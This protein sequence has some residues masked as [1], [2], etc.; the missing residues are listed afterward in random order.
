VEDVLGLILGGGRGERLYPLT[1]HRSEPAVPLAGKYRLIDIPVS[2][3]IHGGVTRVY[4]LTQF[5]SASLHR[6]IAQ[7]YKFDPF[8]HGFV[9]VLAAQQTNETADWYKGTADAVRQNI[10]FIRMEESRDVL[11]LSGDQLYRMDFSR[12]VEEHRRRDADVSLAVKPVRGTEAHRMGIVRCDDDER[13]A[14]VCEKPGSGAELDRLRTSPEWLKDRGVP[15]RGADYLANMGIYLF[16]TTALNSM[17]DLCP[18]S[19]DLVREIFPRCLTQFRIFAHLFDGYWDDLGSIKS[20]HAAHLTLAGDDAPFD[21]ASMEGIIYTRMRNLPPSQVIGAR[22]EQSVIS[23]GCLV[24]SGTRLERSVVGVRSRVGRNVTL[25]ETI[26]NGADRYETTDER[27]DNLRQGVPD[28]G[29]GEESVIERA[30]VDKDCR[31]GRGVRIVNRKGLS[32]AD[33]DNYVIRDGIV[34]IPNATVLPDG[35]EI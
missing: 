7:T 31:I 18:K 4:V 19:V 3:C 35:T 20:Y 13:V 32:Q 6:H 24:G 2:N 1:K 14:E 17:L 34:V 29:I 21:F 23:D 30:I 26:F 16:K 10:N 5:L 11:L 22:I 8:S 25:R 27:A 12:M 9:E 15:S 33:G 28:F